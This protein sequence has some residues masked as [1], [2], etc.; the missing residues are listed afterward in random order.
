[1]KDRIDELLSEIEAFTASSKEHVEEF[2][3]KLLSKKGK[4]KELFEEFK[5]VAPEM[6]KEVGQKLNELQNKA[7]DKINHLKEKFESSDD[8]ANSTIDLTLPAENIAFGSRH[9]L[10]LVRNQIVDIFSRI[11]FTVSE[12]PE[13]EDDWHNFTALNTPADHPARDMQDTFYISENPD[14]VLRTQTSSV[15]VHIMEGTQPP[16]RTISPGRVYRNEAISARA[17]CQFH[18]VEGLY[19]DKKVSFADLK[20][21]LLYFSKE[22]FGEE[23]KIRLRPSYFPFTEI[24]AEMDIS[25][26][27]CKGTGCNICKGAGWVE[28]LGCGMVDPSVLENCKIDSKQYSGFAFGM[29]IERITMLKYQVKDLRLFSENDVRFLKQFKSVI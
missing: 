1:M 15:Q 7:Q 23:T 13:I 14:I 19:I 16:I 22:M 17:H 26:P 10:S 8:A 11:G 4:V 28:I 25:C 27:F 5:T 12:G 2:R 9:P 24:S 29:G 20:Q 3:I 6:R 21:T 18:Q